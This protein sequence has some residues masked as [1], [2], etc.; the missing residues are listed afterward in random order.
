M[1]RHESIVRGLQRMALVLRDG[2]KCILCGQE[3][4]ETPVL[5]GDGRYDLDLVQRERERGTDK[6]MLDV[7]DKDQKDRRK[8]ATD[9]SE[10]RLTCRSCN[11]KV[12]YEA[13]PKTSR[14]RSGEVHVCGDVAGG[15]LS[16]SVDARRTSSEERSD[17]IK[18]KLKE[19]LWKVAVPNEEREEDIL[20]NAP[21]FID[22]RK[23]ASPSAVG[24]WL[25]IFTRS[26]YYP[27]RFNEAGR[28][29]LDKA[30]PVEKQE[31]SSS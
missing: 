24:R 8:R 19:Y 2:N 18:L 13:Y 7:E 29:Y 14:S 1:G 21:V 27:F 22:E 4:F 25:A 30:V 3:G 31:D 6:T 5:R 17:R 9:L 10:L 16:P 15:V 20:I 11:M 12:F 28:I 23:P 26:R